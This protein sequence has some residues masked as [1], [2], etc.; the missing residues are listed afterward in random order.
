[1]WLQE[2]FNGEWM[3]IDAAPHQTQTPD[4]RV[5]AIECCNGPGFRTRYR[6]LVV[7]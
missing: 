7:G 5:A 6:T 3:L 1:M 4:A 2:A